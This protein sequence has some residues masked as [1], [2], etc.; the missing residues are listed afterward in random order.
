MK[1]GAMIS[2]TRY[3]KISESSIK[4]IVIVKETTIAIPKNK[5][6]KRLVNPKATGL[7]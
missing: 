5:T 2:V 3:V 7:S 1:G 6:S 4:E